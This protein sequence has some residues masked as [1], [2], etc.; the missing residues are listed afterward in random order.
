VPNQ[1]S[2]FQLF[3]LWTRKR[4]GRSADLVIFPNEKRLEIFL[5]KTG[6]RNKSLC[7]FNCPSLNCVTTAKD[8]ISSAELLQ[9]VFHGSINSDRLP[10]TLLEALSRFPGRVQLVVIGYETIGS[11]GYMTQFIKEAKRLCLHNDVMFLGA[12]SHHEIIECSSTWKVGL[13]FMPLQ[14]GDIN[15]NNM[16]GAS[17]KPFDYMSCGLALL[18]SMKPEWEAMY[19][20]P[21]YGLSCNPFDVDSI[22]D[23]LRWFLDH[24]AETREMGERGRQ[25]ILSVWNYETQFKPALDFLEETSART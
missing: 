10:L 3:L 25:Q 5:K 22:S 9:L 4:T 19:V 8:M 18:V 1:L 14:G 7:V 12:M 21:G 23:Q 17:N 2:K 11:K 13:A 20:K 24:P 6:R 15:M 16:V